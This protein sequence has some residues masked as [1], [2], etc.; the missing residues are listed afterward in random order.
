LLLFFIVKLI[1]SFIIPNLNKLLQLTSRGCN[2]DVNSANIKT[3]FF[4]H[5]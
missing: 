5:L 4:F 3:N 2:I 1:Y